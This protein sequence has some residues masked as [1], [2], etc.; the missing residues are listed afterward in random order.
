VFIVRLP[1]EADGSKNGVDDFIVRHGAAA[2]DDLVDDAVNT[3]SD[4]VRALR[5]R[6]RE[7]EQQLS[8]Q[9]AVL[10]NAELSAT[11]K[12]VAWSS[13]CTTWV[14]MA[15]Q[16][17]QSR[18]AHLV[19]QLRPGAYNDETLIE[20]LS[21]EVAVEPSQERGGAGVGARVLI[22]SGLLARANLRTVFRS[23]C[24]CLAMACSRLRAPRGPGPPPSARGSV[25][26][27]R[28]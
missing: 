25:A 18:W 3:S 27:A 5:A 26:S 21:V 14:A 15:R 11:Q 10:R 22:A 8:A 19:F 20:F 7:L 13:H 1:S 9:A 12:V 17:Q 16:I 6:V 2:L 24:R 28:S 23:R 4:A